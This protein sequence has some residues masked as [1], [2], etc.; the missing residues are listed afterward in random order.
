MSSH[1]YELILSPL[2]E[3]DFAD[4]LQYTFETW[5]KKQVFIYRAVLD[6]ALA[7]I[8]K[9]PRIGMLKPELSPKHRIFSAGQ[10]LII[11][12]S[13]ENAVMISRILHKR[14][15]YHNQHLN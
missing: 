5:D 7:M 8:Q 9:N 3:E 2:A 1:E 10:H 15:D 11:Y 4:I 6:R 12:Y 14:M 13:T